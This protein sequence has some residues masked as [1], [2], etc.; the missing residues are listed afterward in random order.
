MPCCDI[1]ALHYILLV[2]IALRLLLVF[3]QV[4]SADSIKRAWATYLTEG[5]GAVLDVQAHPKKEQG[6]RYRQK[7][8]SNPGVCRADLA[9]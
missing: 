8:I 1:V 9:I 7:K 4:Q 5:G 2:N 3:R 6:E